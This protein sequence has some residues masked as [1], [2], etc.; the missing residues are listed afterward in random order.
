MLPCSE[1]EV[2]QI[3]AGVPAL[4]SPATALREGVFAGIFRAAPF[5]RVDGYTLHPEGT[6][7]A[8][9]HS[10]TLP[11]AALDEHWRNVVVDVTS[12]AGGVSSP[13]FVASLAAWLVAQ[14]PITVALNDE[15]GGLELGRWP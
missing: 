2:A 9:R 7:V 10:A 11:P 12:P 8:Y 4:D 3:L 1:G 14:Q 13:A 15:D 5:A 6:N